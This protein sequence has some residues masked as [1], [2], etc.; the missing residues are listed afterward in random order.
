MRAKT[1]VYAS[2]G[3]RDAGLT[4]DDYATG[5]IAGTVAMAEDVNTYGFRSD[6]QLKIVSDEIC[7]ALTAQGIVLNSNDSTQLSSMIRTKMGM[8][9]L[10]T[11]LLYESYTTAPTLSNN[12]L[13]FPAFEVWFNTKVYYGT[14]QADFLKV[15]VAAQTISA[16]NAWTTGPWYLYVDTTGAIQHQNS[17]VL[18]EDGATKC[19][20][21]SVF[22]YNGRFQDGSWSFEPW[23]QQTDVATRSSPTAQTKGGLIRPASSTELQMGNLQLKQEG[24]NYGFNKFN[25]DIKSINAVSPFS[26][27]FLYPGYNPGSA[28]QTTLDTT[29]LYN[30]TSGTW[31]NISA[32]AGKFI[33]MVPCVMPTGQTM[34]IP[35]MSYK[36]GTTYTQIFDTALDAEQAIFSLPYSLGNVAKRA[37]YLGQSLIVRIGTTD[38]T[39]SDNFEVYGLVPQALGGFTD[40][41]GQSG[42]GTGGFVPMNEVT[43]TGSSVS[44]VNQASNRV[45]ANSSYTVNVIFPALI[46]GKLNQL[47]V[48][49]QPN[50]SQLPGIAFPAGTKWYNDAAPDIVA[51]IDYTFIF[52]F[53][54]NVNAWVGGYLETSV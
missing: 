46:S 32:H 10:L 19:Y 51:G 16:T 30:L 33:V 39:D 27:K 4:D 20:L 36:S 29:H 49:F 38:I 34:L 7:N 14:K 45:T 35:A 5:M 43:L 6:E 13:S 47:E 41:G 26:Y 3:A 15:S 23:L 53:N 2:Q 24:I 28:A 1:V 8:G 21:G 9:C 50:S 44:L 42:G 18:G 12:V 17:P 52:E 54:H 48:K 11:G 31:D 40:Q 25:P 22:V 37:I